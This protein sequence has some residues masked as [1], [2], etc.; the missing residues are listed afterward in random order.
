MEDRVVDFFLGLIWI[1]IGAA[2][3]L[4]GYRFFR[5][6]LPIFGFLAG[7]VIGAQAVATIFN[8]GFLASLLGI[9]AG[10]ALG[11]LLAF[12]SY[13]W[14]WLGVII[15]IGAMGYAI[16]YGLLPLI[17]I[18]L[19]LVN[20]LIGLAFGIAVAAVAAL[21]QLPRLLVIFWT[22]VWGA[23]TAIIG[24]LMVIGRVSSDD[25]GYGGIDQYVNHEW[26]WL[27]AWVVLAAAG[28]VIQLYTSDEYDIVPPSDGTFSGGP[29]VPPP[30]DHR[31]SG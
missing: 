31:V 4:A 12:I 11:L 6:L 27:A 26:F 29:S 17:G 18:D 20:V 1:L 22:S 14:W 25:L 2:A 15:A 24:F 7:F 5:V 28:V 19:D 9:L 23:A 10:I 13:I 16:G 3:L 8:E 30:H 21:F